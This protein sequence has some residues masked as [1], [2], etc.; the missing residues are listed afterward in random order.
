MSLNFSLPPLGII[1]TRYRKMD[2]VLPAYGHYQH[3]RITSPAPWVLQVLIDRP[4]AYNTF[5]GSM[6]RDFGRIMRQASVDDEC[7]VVVLSATDCAGFSAGID[8][9]EASQEDAFRGVTGE[10]PAR[11]AAKIRRYIEEF[12]Q[13]ISAA[14]T[15]EKRT[16]P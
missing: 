9:K 14:E 6:W 16:C 7:R 12:Q 4:D 1:N 2:L 15:C 13:Q 10:D 11:R 8:L 3:F 5:T